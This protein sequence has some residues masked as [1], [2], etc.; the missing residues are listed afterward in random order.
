M[1]DGNDE[2]GKKQKKSAQRAL[3]KTKS[4]NLEVNNHPVATLSY[5]SINTSS[6]PVP[7]V[8]CPSRHVTRDYLA[9]DEQSSCVTNDKLEYCKMITTATAFDTT[10]DGELSSEDSQFQREL[11][12]LEVPM[13][14]CERSGV[15]ISYT[16]VCDYERQCFDNSD[17]SFCVY[18][19]CLVTGKIKN[20]A[21]VRFFP[22]H[23][24]DSR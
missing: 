12:G 22:K 3:V 18:D 19:K 20:K 24:D 16:M 21:V 8:V 2:S 6:F 5:L 11:M 10:D 1:A 23:K 9:C 13:F 7:M 15:A 4:E 14:R 17:E